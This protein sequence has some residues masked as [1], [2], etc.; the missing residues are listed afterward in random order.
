MKFE[1]TI[2]HVRA[3]VPLSSEAPL[4]RR[5]T[6]SVFIRLPVEALAKMGV[7]P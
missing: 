6:K 7:H 3:S 4:E 5:M 2:Q 1:M